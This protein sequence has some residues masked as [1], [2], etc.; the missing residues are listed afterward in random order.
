ML[1]NQSTLLFP[2]YASDP[3]SFPDAASTALMASTVYRLALL[4]DV[5]H[6]LPEA[7]KVRGELFGSGQGD[8]NGNGHFDSNGWLQPVVNPNAYTQ[9]GSQSPEAQAFVLELQAAWGD[10]DAAGRRGENGALGGR[11]G[12][13]ISPS[14]LIMGM[15]KFEN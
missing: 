5:W 15:W 11:F 8:G 7:E 1:A 9:Q 14:L 10:W 12:T 6:W 4:R 13:I 3:T 2:N